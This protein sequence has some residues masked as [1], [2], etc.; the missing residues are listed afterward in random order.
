MAER[1]RT[2]RLPNESGGRRHIHNTVP[3]GRAGNIWAA[4]GVL[5]AGMESTVP[6]TL[7]TDW[8]NVYVRELTAKELLHGTPVL[9][10]LGSGS[11]QPVRPRLRSAWSAIMGR[12]PMNTTRERKWSRRRLKWKLRRPRLI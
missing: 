6:R 10:R 3:N 7:Y 1:T 8:K 9:T 4:V 2:A 5:R 11:L 12:P